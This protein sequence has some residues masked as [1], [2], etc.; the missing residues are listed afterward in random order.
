MDERHLL[1]AAR[2]V[3]RNPVRAS[4]RPRRGLGVVERCSPGRC[5]TW[6]PTESTP[7]DPDIV[8]VRYNLSLDAITLAG[9]SVPLA[10]KNIMS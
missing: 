7:P 4:L 2:Y 5:W 10:R 6:S 9:Q 3:E 8:E 1:A